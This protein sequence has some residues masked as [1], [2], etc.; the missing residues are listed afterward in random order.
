MHKNMHKTCKT[1]SPT[2]GKRHL[3]R[4]KGFNNTRAQM[5][6]SIYHMTIRLH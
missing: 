2:M 5:L 3:D 6:D 1:L 4:V